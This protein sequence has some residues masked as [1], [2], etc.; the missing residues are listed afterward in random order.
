MTRVEMIY[1]APLGKI[2]IHADDC[3]FL[4]DLAA[5]KVLNELPLPEA[6][7]IKQV[8]WN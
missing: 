4:Y 1:P 5:R 8:H 3:L 2:L 7:I 6:T